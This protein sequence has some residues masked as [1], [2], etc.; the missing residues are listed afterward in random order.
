MWMQNEAL[1]WDYARFGG[2]F[3]QTLG[4]FDP[5]QTTETMME[6]RE[7]DMSIFNGTAFEG[8]T[9]MQVR[10]RLTPEQVKRLKWINKCDRKSRSTAKATKKFIG[11]SYNM[12]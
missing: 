5:E 6:K 4:S 8:L 7:Y 10:R 12:L 2:L 9:Y 11:T 3:R 1:Q